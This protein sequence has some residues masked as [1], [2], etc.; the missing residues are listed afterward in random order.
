MKKTSLILTAFALTLSFLSCTND[1]EERASNDGMVVITDPV[2]IR[3]GSMVNTVTTRGAFE[4][5]NAVV[6]GLGIFALARAP[7]GINESPEEIDWWGINQNWSACIMDNVEANKVYPPLQ[8]LQRSIAWADEDAHYFYPMTQ[9]YAYDFYT[10]YPRVADNE[11]DK[12]Q[13]NK[14]FTRYT[15]DGMTDI[16][17]GRATS[18]EEKGF[19]AAYFTQDASHA[20]LEEYLPKLNIRH[21]LTRLVFTAIPAPAYNGSSDYTAAKQMKVVA[22][23]VVNAKTKVKL[24][25]ADLNADITKISACVANNDAV[26]ASWWNDRLTLT[27]E[28]EETLVL[29][30]QPDEYGVQPVFAGAMVPDE[31][32]IASGGVQ[33]GESMLL[34]PQDYYQIEVDLLNT[35]DNTAHV[36]EVPLIIRPTSGSFMPGSQYNIILRVGG[37]KEI[38]VDARL[39]D[40]IEGEGVKVLSLD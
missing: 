32:T 2:E 24:R 20:K 1:I 27:S 40:W 33:L 12:S 4:S 38:Q 15:L 39:S 10:Y 19:S 13:A 3:L 23:R 26:D 25:I 28:D 16:L 6:N 9:F 36:S 7:M 14:L 21:L 5:D 30:G 18:N 35:A 11:L 37:P 29:H 17:W 34:Y 22:I 31:S 8:D